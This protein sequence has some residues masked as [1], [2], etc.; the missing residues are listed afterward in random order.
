MPKRAAPKRRRR[1]RRPVSIRQWIRWTAQRLRRARLYFGHG[2][3]NARD[4]AAWLIGHI[5]GLAPAA[6]EDHL[7][8]SL[9]AAQRARVPVLVRRRI[10]TRKPLAYLINE[11]W[12]AGERLYVDERVIVPRSHLAEFIGERLRPWIAGARVRRVLDLGTGSGCIAVAA[13]R[14]FPQ[15]RVEASDVSND[16]LAVAAINLRRLQ[17]TRRVRLVQSDLF[18]NLGGS[19]YDVIL[20]NPPYVQRPAWARL[21]REYRHEPALAL[22]AGDDGLEV[23]VR[24]LAA[25]ADHLAAG[26][27]LVVETG[28]SAARLQKIFTRVPFMWLTTAGGDESVFLLTAEQLAQH[29]PLF[30]DV[31]R[32][33]AR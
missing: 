6:L 18:G 11:S 5:A 31:L 19:I 26:G 20:S 23:I 16:A 10:A 22:V 2:T 14:A 9:T 28:N 4:E 7:T 30:A 3:G 12:Y 13:A 25:A 33:R 15:A 1:A 24:I 21:P 29:R 8:Q 17:L 27:V 32:R